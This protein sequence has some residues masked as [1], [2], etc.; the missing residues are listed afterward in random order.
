MPAET[1]I[2]QGSHSIDFSA[3]FFHLALTMLWVAPYVL[4]CFVLA[5]IF[6][7]TCRC[8]QLIVLQTLKKVRV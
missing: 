4:P 7:R 3:E 8:L 1:F 2:K 5:R 6:F